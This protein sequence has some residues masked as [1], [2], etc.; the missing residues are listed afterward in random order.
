MNSKGHQH[1][2]M[3]I[4][5]VCSRKAPSPMNVNSE[6]LSHQDVINLVV[7]FPI[8]AVPCPSS[9]WFVRTKGVVSRRLLKVANSGSLRP[10]SFVSTL[11]DA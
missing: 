1:Q 9:G 8:W 7:V 4:S 3:V 10:L 6:V 11:Q 2:V 5:Y